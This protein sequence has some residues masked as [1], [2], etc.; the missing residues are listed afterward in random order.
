M[1][2][3]SP[4]PSFIGYPINDIF[5]YKNRLGFLADNVILSRVRV[6]QFFP[7]TVAAV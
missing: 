5:I 3:L 2:G 1:S 4:D 6:L 7:E